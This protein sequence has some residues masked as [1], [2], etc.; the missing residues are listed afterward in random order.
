MKNLISMTLGTL[1]LCYGGLAAAEPVTT[2]RVLKDTT[3]MVAVDL[4][5]Q[6]VFCTDRGYGNVQLKVSVPDLDVLAHFDHRVVGE[7][8]PCI[9]GGACDE[10]RQPRDI[11]DPAHPFEVIPVRVVL[12]ENV[13]VDYE[14]HTCARVLTEEVSSLIRR[15]KFVHERGGDVEQVPFDKCQA[16]SGL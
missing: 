8:L 7:G 3:T 5:E 11:I 6:T 4:N 13:T 10:T 1:A 12:K 14:A 9:T 2:T 16:L 15:H